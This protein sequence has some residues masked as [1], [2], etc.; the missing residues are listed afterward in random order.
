MTGNDHQSITPSP[1]DSFSDGPQF[2]I[3]PLSRRPSLCSDFHAGPL[4]GV[5]AH[6]LSAFA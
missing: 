6:T 3:S 1:N 4:I 2:K 5:Y